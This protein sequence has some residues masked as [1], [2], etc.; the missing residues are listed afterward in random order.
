MESGDEADVVKH[1]VHLRPTSLRH[2]APATLHL[3]PCEVPVNRPA[4]VE[5]FFTPAIRQG[6]DGERSQPDYGSREPL[7]RR[8]ALVG[9][10]GSEGSRDRGPPEAAGGPLPGLPHGAWLRPS[11]TPCA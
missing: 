10:E 8:R 5:R 2:A 1:R 11:L 4:P 3:L 9:V 6:P 7:R